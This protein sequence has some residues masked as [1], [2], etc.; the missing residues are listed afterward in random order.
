MGENVHVHVSARQG[1]SKWRLCLS[2]SKE[3]MNK[4][5]ESLARPINMMGMKKC[6]AID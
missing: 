6:G 5:N 1:E 4:H 3:A 2:S